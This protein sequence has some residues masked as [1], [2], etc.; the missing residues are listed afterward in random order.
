MTKGNTK[1]ATILVDYENVVGTNGLKGTDALQSE[2]VFII[3]Y[4]SCC[5][6]IRNEYLQEINDSGCEFRIIKLKGTGKNAL[7]FYIATECGIASQK[8][9]KQLAIISNDK[10][11][12]AVMDFFEVINE[13]QEIQI[14]R[15]G[16]VET[17]L[18]ML[19]AAEN[20][21]RRKRLQK[22]MEMLDLETEYSKLEKNERR[23][24]KNNVR[25]TNLILVGKGILDNIR[26]Q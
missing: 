20:A 22:R 4:S 16:N 21:V 15:T 8:G 18:T 1:M 3:F 24:G 6:K 9:E 11:Y 17:A 26:H 23:H 5:G 19:E 2:D 25:K 7:D 12:Q 10:G 14:V 13:A